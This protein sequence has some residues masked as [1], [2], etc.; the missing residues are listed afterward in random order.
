MISIVTKLVALKPDV[1][2]KDNILVAKSSLLSRLFLLFS[3]NKNVTI[4]KNKQLITIE[5]T[6]FWFFKNKI[7][8][9]FK[10]IEGIYYKYDNFLFD[11]ALNFFTNDQIEEFSISLQLN[12][13]RETVKLF[14]FIGEGEVNA[15]FYD[16]ELIKISGNQEVSSKE[17]IDLLMTFT[18]KKLL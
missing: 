13:P 18:E 12:G 4:N 11:L 7:Y 10:R 5:S 15:P 17:F 16:E 1:E 3:K 14:S 8:I 6:N 2:A 9:P